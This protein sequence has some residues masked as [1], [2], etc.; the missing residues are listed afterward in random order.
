MSR[1]HRRAPDHP[2]L[3]KKQDKTSVSTRPDWL[4]PIPYSGATQIIFIVGDPVRQVKAPAGLTKRLREQGVDFLVVPAQVKPADFEGFVA[5]IEQMENAVGLIITVPHKFAAYRLCEDVDPAAARVGSVN[6]MRLRPQGGWTGAMTDGHGCVAALEGKG[7]KPAGKQVLLVGAGGAGIAV[8]DTLMQAGIQALVVHDKD[9]RRSHHLADKIPGRA[10]ISVATDLPDPSRFDLIVNATLLGTYV[11]D[12]LPLPV[13]HLGR[14]TAV[15]DLACASHGCSA[16]IEQAMERGCITMSGDEM[17]GAMGE[18]LTRFF[19]VD[20]QWR[21]DSIAASSSSSRL[22]SSVSATEQASRL[23]TSSPASEAAADRLRHLLNG[24]QT[25]QVIHVAAVLGIADQLSESPVA[26]EVISEAVGADS[27]SLYRLL[28]A[29]CALDIFREHSD[30]HFSLAPMGSW[31]RTEATPSVRPWAMFLAEPLRWQVWGHLLD[32]V[33]TGKS[34]FRLIHGMDSWQY[35]RQ[36]PEQGSLFQAAMSANSQRIDDVVVAACDL[37]GVRH[38]GDI[39]GGRGSLLAAFLTA[40]PSLYGTLFDQPDVIATALPTF[41]TSGTEERCRLIGGDMFIETPTGCDAFVMKFI[42][43]DWN[44]EAVI[45]ILES[46]RKALP[47]GGRLFIVE[48]LLSPPNQGLYE[49][50]SDL[51]MLLAH[52]GRERTRDQYESLLRATGLAPA[53]LVRTNQRICIL[54]AISI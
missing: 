43:H 49:K 36:H 39:G 45:L 37:K 17:F 9:H 7:F 24:Y 27:D 5:S 51:N 32:S 42:L 26:L 50:M 47:Q 10:A 20:R 14:E 1:E 54:E 16:L 48:Y 23:P 44:D 18:M 6:L 19:L 38:L 11:D 31:L 41:Q 46:C 34:A 4:A 25:T 28:R 12:P 52:G 33:R 15:A 40:H 30:R 29:L 13:E 3:E 21:D 2:T 53:S 8:A 22:G 35:R